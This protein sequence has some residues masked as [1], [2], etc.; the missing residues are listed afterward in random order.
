[1]Y[2]FC[3][4]TGFLDEEWPDTNEGVWPTDYYEWASRDESRF[5]F[6]QGYL[7]WRNNYSRKS[8]YGAQIVAYGEIY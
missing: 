5:K 6:T 7:R 3:D 4:L 2:Y 1:M 8:F